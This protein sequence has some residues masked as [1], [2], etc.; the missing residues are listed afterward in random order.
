[1]GRVGKGQEKGID[2]R[3]K[4]E[5]M[6]DKGSRTSLSLLYTFV[7]ALDCHGGRSD[8]LVMLESSIVASMGVQKTFV[9]GLNKKTEV[10]CGNE[11]GGI[12][13]MGHGDTTPILIACYW[14]RFT[15]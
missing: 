2:M 13:R 1:M 11:L 8:I 4:R 10:V 7:F 5:T 14:G 12:S 9:N 3:Q 15:F 6:P